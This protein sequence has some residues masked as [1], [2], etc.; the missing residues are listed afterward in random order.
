MSVISA[1]EAFCRPSGNAITMMSAVVKAIVV[2]PTL[3]PLAEFGQ[4]IKGL[5]LNEIAKFTEI[6][7]G[8]SDDSMPPGVSNEHR[9]DELR[10]LVFPSR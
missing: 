4:E 3:H 1:S 5:A 2:L 9:G 6:A 8:M 7:W 10:R